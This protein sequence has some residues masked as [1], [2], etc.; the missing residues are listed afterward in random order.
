MKLV[1]FMAASLLAMGLAACQ[2]D[3]PEEPESTGEQTEAESTKA[4]SVKPAGETDKKQGAEAAIQKQELIALPETDED[5]IQQPVGK[6]GHLDLAGGDE[7][8]IKPAFLEAFG[9]VPPLTENATEEEMDLYFNYLYSLM[10][11]D[12]QNPQDVLDQLEY[13]LSGTPEADERFAFK[14]NYNVEIILDASG[15]MANYI[16]GETR[17]E[18]AK[19]SIRKFMAEVPEEANVSLRIYGHEGT[20]SEADKAASCAAVEEIYER[21]TYEKE[22][23][24][25]ALNAFEP[26]GWTPVAGALESA[27]ESFAGLDSKTNTNLI[28]MVSDGIETCGGDPVATAKTLAASD[29][30]P[31][32]NVIGFN[33]DAEAQQQLKDVAEAAN[34]IFSNVT[35]GKELSEQFEQSEEVL[36]NW[37]NWKMDSEL[38]VLKASNAS[39]LAIQKFENHWSSA[40]QKQELALSRGV[41]YLQQAGY[42]TWDQVDYLEKKIFAISD[43][44]NASRTPLVSEL[45]EV[46]EKGL[47]EM[48]KQIEEKYPDEAA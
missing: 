16:G 21:G 40:S 42:I 20:G 47:S 2:Q 15:S 18:L 30:S 6:I 31:I 24:E 12:F 33:A 37:K 10:A 5:L 13:A 39:W 3:E 22:K 35:D 45:N 44:A 17:M 26:A 7:K 41:R 36:R 14:E 28:Y 1:K 4:K 23:F 19:D 38:D 34:G 9:D 11:H 32:I 8:E 27:K 48:R 46:K 29:I 43:L 25:K